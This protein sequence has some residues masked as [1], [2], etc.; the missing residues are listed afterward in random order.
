MS[1]TRVPAKPHYTFRE[2]TRCECYTLRVGTVY[3]YYHFS[4]RDVA[5]AVSPIDFVVTYSDSF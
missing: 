4:E 2:V 3:T 1:E 5:T